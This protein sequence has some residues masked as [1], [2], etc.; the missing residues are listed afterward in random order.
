M[1]GPAHEARGER[2]VRGCHRPESS[3]SSRPRTLGAVELLG[4]TISGRSVNS[5]R[6]GIL[7]GA[8]SRSDRG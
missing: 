1:G 6:E 2:D 3:S 4:G 8:G 5:C 7:A